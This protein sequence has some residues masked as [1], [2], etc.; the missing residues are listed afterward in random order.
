MTFFS[1]IALVTLAACGPSVAEAERG[2]SGTGDAEGVGR[3]TVEQ[4]RSA[5]PTSQPAASDPT[6]ALLDR[7]ETAAE[8]LHDFSADITYFL[9]D[10]ILERREIRGGEIVYD[11]SP[12]DGSR[13]FAILVTSVIVDNRKDN[14][15][16]RYIFDGSWFVEIDYDNRM[17]TK[18][19]IVAPGERFD[20]L[21][22]GE[23]PFPLPVG[24]RRED[25]LARFEASLLDGTRNKVLAKFLAGKPVEGLK[26][27]PRPSTPQAREIA[28]VEIFYD[29]ATLLPLGI[30]LT[31]TNGNRKTVLLRHLK[32]NR[33]ID[34]SKLSIEEPDPKDWQIDVR[35][36]GS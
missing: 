20:P 3:E 23:G 34:E 28:E 30:V 35:P 6:V 5:Q 29:A 26:L 24:Q 2:N 32:R 1:A 11:V 25:V 19:Q 18:R 13:R 31:E 17:F 16:K 27:V 10:A 8:D 7:L 33:G 12:D 21:K 15:N 22:L 4:P 9:W 14:Q 36:W